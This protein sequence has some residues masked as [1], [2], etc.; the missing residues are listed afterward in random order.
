M[1]KMKKKTWLK[2][3]KEEWK[4][5]LK[6]LSKGRGITKFDFIGF[7]VETYGKENKFLM[8]GF[9]YYKGETEKREVYKVFWS[10]E[11]MINYLFE[12]K[13]LFQRKY[14]V[15]TNLEFDFTVLFKNSE[16]WNDFELL[17]RG[18]NLIFVKEKKKS[19]HGY[20]KFID[21]MNYIPMGVSAWGELLGESKLVSPS[22][23]I[24][25]KYE[26]LDVT[27][28][29]KPKN[30]F[31]RKELEEY[32][33]I[34]CKISCDAMYLLQKGFNLFGGKNKIT[35]ASTAMDVFRRS[36][37]KQDFIKES[38]ILKD[39]SVT[40]F[41]FKSYFGGRTEVFERGEFK[42]LYYYDKNSLYPSAMKKRLPLPQS[43]VQMVKGS[44]EGI[45]KYM[46]V[47]EV[48][49][50]C[51]DNLNKPFLPVRKDGKLIFPTGEFRGVYTHAELN[52]AISLGY[53]IYEIGRQVIYRKT[54]RPF[55]EYVET[56]YQERLKQKRSN[57][58]LEKVTKLLMNSL[59]GKFGMRKVTKTKIL[60]DDETL[61]N[62]RM[63]E[64]MGDKLFE[65]KNGFVT[66]KEE[67]EYNGKYQFPI[68]ASYIT[69]YARIMMYDFVNRSDCI[70]TDTDSVI[71]KNPLDD[72]FIGDDLG[73]MK[74]E[75]K[76]SR[77]VFVRP[78]FYFLEEETGKE[79]VKI[80]GV[81]RANTEDFNTILKAGVVSKWKFTRLRE[82][83]KRNDVVCNGLEVQSKSLSLDE[84]KRVWNHLDI[85]IPSS[86]IPIKLKYYQDVG[87]N[88]TE[89]DYENSIIKEEVNIL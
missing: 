68:F 6:P 57:D 77:G 12:N 16:R 49:V 70:Y 34:D 56:L 69:A 31:E 38:Y 52:K 47:S 11:E 87:M 41:I 37:Q 84:N 24:K 2:N 60:R 13:K 22:S 66:Y 62:K 82:S 15:A 30:E 25:Q 74:L 10:S 19:K 80:K 59:Y 5:T 75:A 42:D 7:D 85:N 55:K 33:K 76:C 8:G 46:G 86:S 40:D 39:E 14:I 88:L 1:I 64:E 89:K 43:A 35:S 28:P 23:W 18:S 51:V 27:I 67:E 45:T 36:F 29:R 48:Y 81:R 63:E 83:L 71:L 61:T 44:F 21:T 72:K 78:K 65:L 54:H 17:Y 50:K 26:G 32:N 4:S 79:V 58:P 20:I 53:K 9:F 73:E 3:K